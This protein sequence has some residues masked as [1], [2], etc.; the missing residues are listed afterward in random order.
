M[1]PANHPHD[2]GRKGPSP[3]LIVF[4]VAFIALLIGGFLYFHPKPEG[5][6]DKATSPAAAPRP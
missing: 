1:T 5:A 2:P 3:T 6:I 4:V